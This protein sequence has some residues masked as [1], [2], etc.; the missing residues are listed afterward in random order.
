MSDDL[1]KD[2][3]SGPGDAVQS[4]T[5]EGATQLVPVARQLPAS[6]ALGARGAHLPHVKPWSHGAYAIDRMVNA[7][8]GHLTQGISPV[9][10]FAAFAD[11]LSHLA[12]SPG[13]QHELRVKAWRKWARLALYAWQAP[14]GV[15]ESLIEPLEQDKRFQA[16]EWQRWPYNV[17]YQSFLLG[18]QWW[19]NA[20]CDVR[21]TTRHHEQVATFMTRQWIDMFS[22]SNGLW[23]NPEVMRATAIERGG[24]LLRGAR[25]WWEDLLRLSAGESLENRVGET[26]RPGV[27]LALTP[28]KVVLRNHLIELIQYEPQTPKT[29]AAPVLIVPS[30]IMKYYILD[31]S[32]GNSLVRYLVQQGHT[33]F[34]LS[35][36]NPDSSDRALG[37]DDYLKQG[38]LAATEAVRAIR[39]GTRI[40]AVGYCLGGT[41]L[42]M[43]AAWLARQGDERLQSLSLLAAEVDFTEPGELGLFIDE[44]QLAFLEDIM[45]EQGYLDGKQMAGAFALLNSRDL[46]WSRMVRDYLMGERRPLNDL[47]AW[48]ADA[49]RMPYRQH[50]EYLERLY[51]NN[52]L[53][54]GHYKVDGRPVVLSD[55]RVPFFVVGTQRDTVSPWRSVYKIHLF[56]DMEITFCL[57]TGGHNAGVVNPPGSD[58]G[59]T[60]WVATHA[61]A[62]RY[63]D[64]DT[65]LATASARA[66]SWWP[67]WE[68][69]LRERAG[70]LVAAPAPGAAAA[71]YAVIDEAPG[72]YVRAN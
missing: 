68:A 44:S 50:R 23:T 15:G 14:L 37:M 29:H 38:V 3:G 31:L 39:P 52:E 66:G 6:Y 56:T 4:N 21:G 70:A 47:G 27:D 20:T 69:W 10:V 42:A 63:V 36:R 40:N 49:T 43:A 55:I 51:L 18:Q 34:I 26:L 35:W 61:A 19:H 33:V 57:T 9:S 12:V 1:H 41:L 67:S 24:N 54:E 13:K 45:W 72:Q 16:P 5:V 59:R 28:G 22:P 53:A 62:Q 25:F 46:I 58:A 8:L 11:W 71:G 17:L 30:W 32:A 7:S 64:P 48:N 65:W 2:L 60:H